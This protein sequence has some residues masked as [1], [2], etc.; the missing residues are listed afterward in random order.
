TANNVEKVTAVQAVARFN[1]ATVFFTFSVTQKSPESKSIPRT[2]DCLLRPGATP[3]C[4]ALSHH[5]GINLRQRPTIDSSQGVAK[6]HVDTC[7]LRDLKSN[8]SVA[9]IAFD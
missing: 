5:M 9:T 2:S 1:R 8:N 7:F 4:P 3:L 6:R